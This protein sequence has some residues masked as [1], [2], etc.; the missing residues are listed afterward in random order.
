MAG[1]RRRKKN[2]K[3]IPERSAAKRFAA[4]IKNPIF[5]SENIPAPTLPMANR[6]P[7]VEQAHARTR[8]SPSERSPSFFSPATVGAPTG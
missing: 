1:E 7:E 6:G 5:L 3:M 2:L 8:V 4:R